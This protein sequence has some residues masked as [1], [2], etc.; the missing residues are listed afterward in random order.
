MPPLQHY[1]SKARRHS[2]GAHRFA[3]RIHR[4][5]LRDM[6]PADRPLSMQ[7]SARCL[8]ELSILE[9]VA[10]DSINELE[11]TA[12]FQHAELLA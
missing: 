6:H 9:Y 12:V 4:R 11:L 10:I 8:D 3:E 7:P 1:A 2:V 5:L